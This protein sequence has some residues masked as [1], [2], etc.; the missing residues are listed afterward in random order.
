M[1][2]ISS[3]LFAVVLILTMTLVGCG[4]GQDE[5]NEPS[6]TEATTP[7][8]NEPGRDVEQAADAVTDRMEE[9]AEMDD[10]TAE[11]AEQ[12]MAEAADA[13]APEDR[14]RHGSTGASLRRRR[15]R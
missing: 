5:A 10:D 15:R 14:D 6:A 3:Q 7:T 8:A 4:G 2:K 1:N 9:S 13:M 12:A 11:R